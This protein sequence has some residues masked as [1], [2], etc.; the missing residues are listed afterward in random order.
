M[1]LTSERTEVKNL[2][3]TKIIS[4]EVPSIQIDLKVDYKNTTGRPEY[5]ASVALQSVASLRSY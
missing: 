1:F 4:E 3:F 2:I 5:Q